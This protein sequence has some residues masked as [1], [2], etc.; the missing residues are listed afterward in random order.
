MRRRPQ[1][2][3]VLFT[4]FIW[5]RRRFFVTGSGNDIFCSK[6]NYFET[7]DSY[8]PPP[9]GGGEMEARGGIPTS[10]RS[11]EVCAVALSRRV[12]EVLSNKQY[13]SLTA[14]RRVNKRVEATPNVN[15][16]LLFKFIGTI[17]E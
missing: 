4:V 7:R 11:A 12:F 15:K 13:R 8:S 6:T 9:G 16:L 2:I 5:K 10:L 14:R 17:R 3:T 1:S